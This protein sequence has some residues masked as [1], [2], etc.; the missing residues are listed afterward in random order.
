MLTGRR[1]QPQASS[2][3]PHVLI[4]GAGLARE[5]QCLLRPGEGLIRVGPRGAIVESGTQIDY[6]SAEGSRSAAARWVAP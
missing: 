2:D 5:R 4:V 6:R 3:A 1:P